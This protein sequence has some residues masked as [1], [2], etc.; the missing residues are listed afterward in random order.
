MLLLRPPRSTRDDTSLHLGLVTPPFVAAPV[1]AP[2]VGMAPASPPPAAA[3]LLL[4]LPW[5][6]LKSSP[7]DAALACIAPLPLVPANALPPMAEEAVAVVGNGVGVGAA[8]KGSAKACGRKK[9]NGGG[10]TGRGGNEL[11]Q[12]L[13]GARGRAARGGLGGS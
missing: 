9:G 13:G 7:L 2:P 8:A 10:R 3:V 4:L 6:S 12:G 5:K 1:P 11:A